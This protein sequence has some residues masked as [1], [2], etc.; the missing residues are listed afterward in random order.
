MLKIIGVITLTMITCAC[1]EPSSNSIV[2]NENSI[3]DKDIITLIEG[4][5]YSNSRHCINEIDQTAYP[6]SLHKEKSLKAGA[7]QITDFKKSDTKLPA[8]VEFPF[9]LSNMDSWNK[10]RY[11]DKF[12]HFT[13]FQFD[14]GIL[15]KVT[16]DGYD[17]LFQYT[18]KAWGQMPLHTES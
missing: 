16:D 6:F 8:N 5:W 9:C 18:K 7:F 3:D 17:F 10:Y 15:L 4:E 11:K 2:K 12:E 13:L 14:N 1:T